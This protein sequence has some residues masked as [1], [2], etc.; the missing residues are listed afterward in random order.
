VIVVPAYQLDYY[1]LAAIYCS[2]VIG[3][4]LGI[5]LGH[6]LFDFIGKLVRSLHYYPVT[7]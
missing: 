1:G 3:G 2:P 5:P 6:Y 7:G 4:I